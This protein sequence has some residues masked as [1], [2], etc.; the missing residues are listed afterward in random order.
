MTD[1]KVLIVED[2]NALRDIY[3]TVIS[4]AGIETITASTGEEGVNLATK[5]HPDVIMMDVMLPD[6][7]GHEAVKKIRLDAWGKKAKIIFLTNRDDAESIFQA[8]EEGSEEYIIKS[9]TSNQE[10]LNKVRASMVS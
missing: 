8:V 3:Q 1:R 4:G 2:D 7:S 9:H 10:L 5:H 6:I